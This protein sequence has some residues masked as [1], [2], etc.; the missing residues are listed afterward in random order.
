MGRLL[1]LGCVGGT[2]VFVIGANTTGLGNFMVCNNKFTGVGLL[3]P[4]LWGSHLYLAL[5]TL[6]WGYVFIFLY[7]VHGMSTPSTSINI[8]F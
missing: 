1:L 5:L 4:I 3:N 2:I 6:G 7:I 8:S